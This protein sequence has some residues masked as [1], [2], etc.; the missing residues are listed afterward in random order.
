MDEQ[1]PESDDSPG[2]ADLYSG[3]IDNHAVSFGKCHPEP[4]EFCNGTELIGTGDHPSLTA[5]GQGSQRKHVRE[6]RLTFLGVKS[7][8]LF[9][10]S[11]S[12]LWMIKS[13]NLSFRKLILEIVN[14]EIMEQAGPRCSTGIPAKFSGNTPG[15]IRHI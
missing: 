9:T 12:Y 13:L 8:M 6:N 15:Y 1:S 4:T 5:F 14:T 11:G 2:I 10:R 3:T 7:E